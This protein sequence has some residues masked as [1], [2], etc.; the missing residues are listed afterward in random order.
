M[1]LNIV[2]VTFL[3]LKEQVTPGQLIVATGSANFLHVIL[4]RL[5]HVKVDHCPDILH[6]YSHA[7][8][9]SGHDHAQLSFDKLVLDTFACGRRQA[10]MIRLG[11]KQL[12][13]V[14][15][16]CCAADFFLLIGTLSCNRFKIYLVFCLE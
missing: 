15:Y 4:N 16:F 3:C 8:R 9:H 5:G 12:R 7:E 10:R 6:V 14:L 11:Y 1:F 13:V 2:Y